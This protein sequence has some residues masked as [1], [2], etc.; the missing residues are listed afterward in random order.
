MENNVPVNAGDT[1]LIPDTG[2][3]QNATEQPSPCATTIEH[4]L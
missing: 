4:V 3:S 1:G 2:V